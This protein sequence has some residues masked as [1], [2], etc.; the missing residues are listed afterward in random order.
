MKIS[1][2]SHLFFRPRDMAKSLAFY[3]ETLGLVCELFG[4]SNAPEVVIVR[5]GGG[6]ALVLGTAAHGGPTFTSPAP[7]F[8]L[9]L[10][11]EDP[12]VFAKEI[13]QRGV[14]ITQAPHDTHWAT[15]MFSAKDPDGIELHFERPVEQSR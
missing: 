11:V 14:T 12:D 9:S 13:I 1:G 2:A 10:H 7:P 4:P 15:R 8:A 6:F 3:R 5:L